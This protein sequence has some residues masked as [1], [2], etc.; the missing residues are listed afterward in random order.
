[1]GKTHFMEAEH[2]VGWDVMGELKA[3]LDPGGI[4]NPGKLLR[5]QAS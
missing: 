4:L 2:G 3:L 1:M 5:P